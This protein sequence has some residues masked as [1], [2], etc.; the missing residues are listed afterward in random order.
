MF[1][2]IQQKEESIEQLK[3]YLK[4]LTN[5]LARTSEHIQILEL[6]EDLKQNNN[7]NDSTI[8]HEIDQLLQK[9]NH[10]SYEMML[11]K[12][13]IKKMSAKTIL[14]T[15]LVILPIIITLLFFVI[16]DYAVQITSTHQIMK[17]TYNA[18][19][20]KDGSTVLYSHW[21]ITDQTPLIVSIENNKNVNQHNMQ[22]IKNAILS[23]DSITQSHSMIHSSGLTTDMF[24]KGWQGA[25]QTVSNTKHP[26]PKKFNI[27]QS[28]N[29]DGRITITLLSDSEEHG[30]S[31]ITKT[32][33]NGNQILKTFITIYNSD[34]LT[35]NQIETIIRHEFGHALGLPPVTGDVDRMYDTITTDHQYISECDIHTLEKIYNDVDPSDGLC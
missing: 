8:E 1:Q 6:E 34:K 26:M 18:E 3:N 32:L 35:D 16:E 15:E 20:L 22:A 21:N 12:K 5:E 27:I 7:Y 24:F 25:V 10:I 31:S 2:K 11:I 9:Q 13:K 29:G 4:H 28:N 30:Y 14:K 19:D 33:T 17:T 23:T